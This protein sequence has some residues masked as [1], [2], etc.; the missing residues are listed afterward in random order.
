M[1]IAE[2]LPR[3]RHFQASGGVRSVEG[4]DGG[5]ARLSPSRAALT[6]KGSALSTASRSATWW[7]AL[8]VAREEGVDLILLGD[9]PPSVVLHM[10]PAIG[11]SIATVANQGVQLATVP[12]A[13]VK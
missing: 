11:L 8:R 7:T 10:L 13:V 4:H 12:V 9:R 6:R 2:R 1:T 3:L 5:N